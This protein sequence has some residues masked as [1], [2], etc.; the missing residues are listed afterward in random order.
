MTKKVDLSDVY[1]KAEIKELELST[2]AKA[3]S[4]SLQQK[5]GEH[6]FRMA[7]ARLPVTFLQ[8]LEM[9]LEIFGQILKGGLGVFLKGRRGKSILLIGFTKSFISQ[10]V[11]LSM[12]GKIGDSFEIG[13]LKPT[14]IELLKKE[15]EQLLEILNQAIPFGPFSLGQAFPSQELL[16]HLGQHSRFTSYSYSVEFGNIS[17]EVHLLFLDDLALSMK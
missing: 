10:V 2:P 3:I 16:L 1:K 5:L 9:N 14:S 4:V 7:H 6:F 11:S 15:S 8:A 17:S 13:E 12:G